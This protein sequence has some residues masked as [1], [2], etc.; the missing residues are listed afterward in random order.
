MGIG[1]RGEPP[2]NGALAER[3]ERFF[4]SAAMLQANR[5]VPIDQMLRSLELCRMRKQRRVLAGAFR[6]KKSQSA[7]LSMFAGVGAKLAFNASEYV[8][9]FCPMFV[10]PR[11]YAA[12]RC[13]LA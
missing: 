2:K 7:S 13:W 12:F 8:G 3:D 6:T 9:G 10:R 5:C 1:S 4:R 11:S